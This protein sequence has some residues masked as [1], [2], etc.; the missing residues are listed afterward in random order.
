M[1]LTG[2]EIKEAIA[3]GKIAAITLDTSIFE[4]N[5]NRFEH[6][7]LARLKQFKGT[8]VHLVASDVVLGEVKS[9]V[10]RDA[11]DAQSKVRT[12]L[13]EVGKAW[14]VS[15]AQRDTAM[16]ALFRDE[17]PEKLADRRITTFRE[18]TSLEIVE[19][20]GRVNV[21]TILG[22]Y[23][24]AMPPFGKSI[25]KKSEFPDALALHALENWAHSMGL[26]L[27]VVSKDGDWQRYCKG[28]PHLVA[29]DD[30]AQAL[31][32]FHQNA[33]VACAR[34]VERFKA[35]DLEIEDFIADA[36][37]RVADRFQFIPQVSSG[38]FFDADV[39]EVDVTFVSIGVDDEA[40]GPFKVVDKPEE[41]VLVVEAEIEVSL[42]VSTSF[43]FSVT[44]PIDKDEVPIGSASATAE[45]P[46]DMRVLLTF[47]GDLAEY[48]ELVDAEVEVGSRR[49]EVDYG[50]VGP[51]WGPDPG[52]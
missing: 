31:S 42:E 6:G 49:I 33:E 32:Y 10:V 39:Y 1:E 41:N 24:S 23:F 29:S 34:L 36:V 26:L 15:Q 18:A 46:M 11:A 50:E 48:A 16:N 22:A 25:A 2:D 37:R 45:V 3:T 8:P 12:S 14:Q 7:L 17:S 35:G 28:S 4:G 5:G 47:E 51:D 40:Q 20:E 52:E 13:K 27:L 43:R 21:G 9:H 19:S 44:D 38:Y 30:L